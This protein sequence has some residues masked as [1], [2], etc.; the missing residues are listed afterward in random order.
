MCR[1][2][3]TRAQHHEC[4]CTVITWCVQHHEFVYCFTKLCV[5]HHKYMST[6]HKQVLTLSS[7]HVY[8]ITSMW[9]NHQGITCNHGSSTWQHVLCL[10][11]TCIVQPEKIKHV[12]H[13]LHN[14]HERSGQDVWI[15]RTVTWHI[16]IVHWFYIVFTHPTNEPEQNLTFQI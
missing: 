3:W 10:Y 6:N 8:Y 11:H 14:N 15:N 9:M 5:Q 12:A 16:H 1:I 4:V 13:L 2:P 7:L